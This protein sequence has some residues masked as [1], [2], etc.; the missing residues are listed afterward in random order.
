MQKGK[1][2][3][4]ARGV[5]SGNFLKESQDKLEGSQNVPVTWWMYKPLDKAIRSIGLPWNCITQ[6]WDCPDV[7]SRTHII[8]R[9]N[10][11]AICIVNN[12][13]TEMNMGK[14]PL[15]L[16]QCVA[17]FLNREQ[18]QEFVEINPAW[19]KNLLW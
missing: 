3:W 10:E 9:Q 12:S 19:K 5:F 15:P 8:C 4:T 18:Y 13:Q 2:I 16:K 17:S 1:E 7:V 11:F 6:S 14:L